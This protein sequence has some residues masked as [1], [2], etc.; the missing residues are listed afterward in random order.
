MTRHRLL[1]S[2]LMLTSAFASAGSVVPERVGREL[3]DKLIVG[4]WHNWTGWPAT[5]S[6]TEVPGDYDVVVVAF[7]TPTVPSGSTMQFVPDP[8]IYPTAAEFIADVEELQAAGKTVLISIGGAADPVVVDDSASAG[9]F[10]SSMSGILDTYGFDGVDVDLE[11]GSLALDPG[12]DDYRY[13]TTPRIVHFTEALTTLMSMY[14][15]HVLSAAPETAYVQGGYQSYAG[16]WGAYLPVI[17]ALRE[18]WSY[19]HVQHYNTG[20]MFGR[21]GNIYQPATADFHVAMADMLLAG[22]TVDA[23]GSAIEFPPLR[24]DQVAV[25]LP[26]GPL[27]GDGYTEPGVVLQALDYLISGVPF[28]GQYVLADPDGY[29]GFR[30]LMTWSVN[31]DSYY[32][33]EFS[34]SYRGYL[35]SLMTSVSEDELIVTGGELTELQAFPS[36]ARESVSIRYTLTTGTDVNCEVVDMGGRRVL[37][38]PF[39]RQTAG[40]HTVRL[41]LTGLPAGLY[42]LR[43]STGSGVLSGYLPVVP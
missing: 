40:E 27:A 15:D 13:P 21:D 10:V 2:L 19:I 11:G 14:P 17:H 30:G 35:D 9:E 1:G 22:F 41:D 16:I 12:D 25:G 28:G 34:S 32:G 43:V 6:L 20:S 24:Q 37:D 36:P 29:P 5:L 23:L 26:A 18:R 38:R 4:Y 3:P 8:G 31:W 7:A 42:L 33:W 39:G